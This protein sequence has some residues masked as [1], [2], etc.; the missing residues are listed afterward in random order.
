MG[1]HLDWLRRPRHR[2][3]LVAASA[4]LAG[5]GFFFTSR[6]PLLADISFSRAVYDRHGVLLR[7]TLTVDEKYRL[8][9]PLA[10]I[11]P[12]LRSAVL[13]H[14][15]QHFYTHPGV[16]PLALWRA[17]ATRLLGGRRI[18]ASTITM[19]LAR[20]TQS[21]DS[22]NFGGKLYQ[23]LCAL[24]LELYYSKDALL[25]AYL[26]RASYGYNIE[27]VGAASLIYYQT[28]AAQLSLPQALTLAVIPQSPARRRPIAGQTDKPDLLAARYRL[29]ARWQAAYTV[30][31]TEQMLL[32][33]PLQNKG[34]RDLPRRAPHMVRDLLRRYSAM[35]QITATIDSATQ[36]QLE[37]IVQ[38]YVRDQRRVGI[39]NA[40]VL[41]VDT[42]NQQ[43]LASIGSADFTNSAINGQVDGTRAK[44]SPGSA[45]KPF[46]YALAFEQGLIHPQSVLT[47]TPTGF[48]SYQPDNFE[49]DFRGPISAADALRFS[50]NIPAIK[51]AAQLKE[52]SFYQFLQR[53]K[54]SGLRPEPDYGLS[55]VLGGAG[56]TVREMAV[57]YT[58]LANQGV[59]QPLKFQ[60]SQQDETPAQRLLTPEASLMALEVLS[61]SPHPLRSED[62][63]RIA[64]KT[65][66]SNGLHDAW[67]AGVFGHYALVVWVGNFSGKS[68]PALV[69]V[70]AAAPLFFALADALRDTPYPVIAQ[71][72]EGLK[73]KQVPVCSTTGNL[74]L[75]GCSSVTSTWFIPGVSPLR[76]LS[77]LRPLLV[78]RQTGLR[79]CQIQP[80]LTEYRTFEVW[81]SDL[82][83]VLRSAGLQ[84]PRLPNW[85]PGCNAA[86]TAASAPIILSPQP[87]VIYQ[88]HV[89]VQSEVILLKATAD[90]EAKTL[91]WFIDN[92]YFGQSSP[93]ESLSWKP[94][95]GHYHILVV[96]D[97]GHS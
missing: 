35:P 22:R 63:G 16:N 75:A 90:G 61:H 79:A 67:T 38:G 45:L 87:H 12:V 95:P 92:R 21:I 20:M 91:H 9:T 55:L 5:A 34:R 77:I 54:V 36:Q 40:S 15:D 96:D 3:G 11:N 72:A 8:F 81:P 13:L 7:L 28:Q 60:L 93:E 65:G 14:E 4:L 66:T 62:D 84:K 25:E 10:A 68:N 70:R 59:M 6:P 80:G 89:G 24:R 82:Q 88:A 76:G 86:S 43:V 64:W 78:N 37:T 53:A 94:A 48:G 58:M 51:L 39:N 69:G 31:E 50:R 23:I 19:Q 18:G 46:I 52:P 32:K 27:G 26:N 97:S 41:L 30:T 2:V 1:H 49:R 57:L 47:D 71:R 44:R 33:L 85:E 29:F 17:V 74:E 83:Q 42:R 73:L 56:V